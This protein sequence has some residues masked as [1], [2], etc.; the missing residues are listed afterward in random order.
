MAESTGAKVFIA[1]DDTSVLELLRI[2]LELAGYRTFYARDGRRAVDLIR[3][4]EPNVVILDIGLP[5]LDGFGVLRSLRAQRRFKD[6]PVLMLTARH[7]ES[8]VQLSLS[9]GAQDYLTKPF[10]D[11]VLLARVAR[12]AQSEWSKSPQSTNTLLV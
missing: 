9:Y 7:A 8:D 1:E 4:V 5:S 3:N 12:L 2:R 11:K 10:N 6:T